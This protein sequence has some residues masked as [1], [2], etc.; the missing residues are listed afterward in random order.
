VNWVGE[1][2]RALPDA[3]AALWAFGEGWRGLI[4]LL[5]SAG[6]AAIFLLFAVRLRPTH[7]WLSSIFGIMSATVA[8]WWGFGILPSAWV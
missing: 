1:F 4:E 3:L 6:L 7:G 5:V 2:F 8:M